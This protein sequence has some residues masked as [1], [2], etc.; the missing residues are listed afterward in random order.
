MTY[1]EQVDSIVL[2][3]SSN[4]KSFKEA[5]DM[6][7]KYLMNM[8]YERNAIERAMQILKNKFGAENEQNS[9]N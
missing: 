7:L 8:S 6:N 5:D 2:D 9:S 1:D 3:L 4:A